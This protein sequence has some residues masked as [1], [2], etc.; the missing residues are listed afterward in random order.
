MAL[1][2]ASHY[3]HMSSNDFVFN[4]VSPL[5]VMQIAN[6][7]TGYFVTV[8]R[9]AHTQCGCLR[10]MPLTLFRP[11]GDVYGDFPMHYLA[12]EYLY[13]Q[14]LPDFILVDHSYGYARRPVMQ[15]VFDSSSIL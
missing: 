8:Q 12:L 3:F 2:G 6:P 1:Q 14:E 7:L 9:R 5:V 13:Y 11:H 15:R 10:G 4:Y